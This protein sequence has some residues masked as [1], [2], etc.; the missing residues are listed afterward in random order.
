MSRAGKAGPTVQGRPGLN[1]LRLSTRYEGSPETMAALRDVARRQGA[2]VSEDEDAPVRVFGANVF[3]GPEDRAT[4]SLNDE[5]RERVL[6]EVRN[7]TDQADYVVVNSHSHEP[8]RRLR[9]RAAVDGGVRA[10]DDRRGGRHVQSSTART[11]CA[12]WE[13]YKGRPIF[14]S[15][16]NFIFQNETIDPMPSDQRDRYGIPLDP[17]RVGDLRHALPS[18]RG[19]E[20][21]DG[22]P[23]RVRVVRERGSGRDPSREKRGSRSSFTPSN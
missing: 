6:H 14:Y 4:V 21:D 1:P 3:P 17:A 10:A 12:A 9:H 20:S 13:I 15:L 8:G 22:L 18:G 16:A 11:S 7:A 23:H 19:R 5:D 2:T